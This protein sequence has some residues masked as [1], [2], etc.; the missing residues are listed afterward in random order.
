MLNNYCSFFFSS[1]SFFFFG[2]NPA[3][4]QTE[5]NGSMYGQSSDGA[6]VITRSAGHRARTGSLICNGENKVRNNRRR[7]NE[8]PDTP[9]FF[10]AELR[11]ARIAPVCE[12]GF[13]QLMPT[14]SSPSDP[15]WMPGAPLLLTLWSSLALPLPPTSPSLALCEPV[16]YRRAHLCPVCPHAHCS[17]RAPAG[18]SP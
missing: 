17:L 12:H 4:R 3:G 13:R 2:G 8:H 18:A 6:S 16:C 15:P 14:R 9:V 11:M 10:R 5:A 7:A 1:S